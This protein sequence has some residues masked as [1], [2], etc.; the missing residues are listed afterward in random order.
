MSIFSPPERARTASTI[1]SI[2][3]GAISS[4]SFGQWGIPIRA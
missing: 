2:D 1:R 3:C 4:P